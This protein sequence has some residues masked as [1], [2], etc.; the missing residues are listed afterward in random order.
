MSTV[1]LDLADEFGP[2]IDTLLDDLCA[3]IPVEY[4]EKMGEPL[5]AYTRAIVQVAATKAAEVL[6]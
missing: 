3:L 1:N 2:I 5:A 6:T 4:M